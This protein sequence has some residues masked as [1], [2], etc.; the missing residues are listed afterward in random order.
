MEAFNPNAS[1]HSM[2]SQNRHDLRRVRSSHD[3]KQQVTEYNRTNSKPGIVSKAI[4]SA[5]SYELIGS[6]AAIA[7]V[8]SIFTLVIK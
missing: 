6:I 2:N 8:G 1:L 7:V 3:F 4:D 5:M